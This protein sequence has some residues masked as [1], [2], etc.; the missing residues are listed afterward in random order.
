MRSS[1]PNPAFAG[2]RLPRWMPPLGWD[3]TQPD[4]VAERILFGAI[5][6]HPLWWILGI[7]LVVYP[8]AGFYLFYRSLSRSKPVTLPIGWQLWSLYIGIWVLS[9]FINLARGLAEV[10]RSATASGSI[11]GVWV[12]TVLTWYAMRRLN[13]RYR[14]IIRAICVL[15]LWQLIVALLGEAYLL[16]TGSALETQ[17]LVVTLVPNIPARIFF[18]AKLYAFERLEWDANPVAR[19]KSFYYWAPLAGT[20]S[21]FICMGALCDRDRLWKILGFA[22][23]ILTLWLAAGRAA[24]T[25]LVV[26]VIL[27]AWF[28]DRRLRNALIW[29]LPLAGLASP[30][31]L[32]KLYDYFFNYRSDSTAGRIALYRETYRA[33]VESPLIGFGAQGR[34]QVLDVPLGSH[35]QVLSTLYQTGLVGSAVL[36]AAWIALTVALFQQVQRQPQLSPLLGAWAGLS[37]SMLTGEL[38][39]ASVTVFVLASWMGCA[40]NWNEQHLQRQYTPWMALPQ[41]AEPPTPWESLRGWW[42]GSGNFH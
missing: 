37:L 1:P 16:A 22:G 33:F 31:I 38:A 25:G 28:G 10:G 24:Q 40:W 36:L 39:A 23:G 6:L 8:I 18:E 42:Q 13:I 26:A 7:Q 17:S 29:C 21:L 35:S 12:L 11:L 4:I 14:V 41:L 5:A 30:V 34:S 15:G 32:S 2:F 3:Q 27:A 19:L 9:I 20:M